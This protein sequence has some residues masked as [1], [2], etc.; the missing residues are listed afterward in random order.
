MK[1]QKQSELEV[2]L[3]ELTGYSA[4]VSVPAVVKRKSKTSTSPITNKTK[5]GWNFHPSDSRRLNMDI[6]K[7]C[8]YSGHALS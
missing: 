8:F 4:V 1:D 3:V 5:S 2:T 6:F 7:S